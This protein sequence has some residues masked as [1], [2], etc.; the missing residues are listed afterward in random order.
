MQKQPKLH[1][2]PSTHWDREWYQ[3]FQDYR[4]RL[5]GLIDDVLE[6]L[7]DET[8][9]GPFTADGQ[10][11]LIEDYLEI[12]PERAETLRLYT[13]SGQ[14]RFGPWYVLPDEFLVCGESLIRN[15]RFGREVVCDFGGT[16]SNAGFLC[17]L[18]GH[19]SQMPQIFDGFGI[20]GALV[21]RGVDSRIG[22]G[23]LWQGADG[24]TLPT[25][26]FGKSGYCDYTYKV[27][28]SNKPESIFED[29]KAREDLRVFIEE[30]IQRVGPISH[31]LIFDGGDHLQIDPDHYGVLKDLIASDNL[32]Y[33]VIHSDLDT[34]LEG[35]GANLTTSHPRLVGELREPARWPTSE[36]MQFLIPGCTASRVWI[37]QANASCESLLIDWVEPFA[38]FAHYL[39]GKEYPTAFLR[40]AWKWLLQNHPHDS[41]CGCSVDQVH[42]DMRY[43]F[44]QCRQIA[45]RLKH[46]SL[47][48]LAI[49]SQ[50][51][52]NEHQCGVFLFN[53]LPVERKQAVLLFD[54]EIPAEWPEFTEFFGY[55]PKPAFRL[56]DPTTGNEVPYQRL[57]TQRLRTRKQTRKL[58]YPRVYK[59]HLVRVAARLDLPALGF[60][61][62][63]IAATENGQNGS[64]HLGNRHV[65]ATRHPSVPG[66]RTASNRIENQYLALTFDLSGTLT[67]E[68]KQNSQTYSGLNLFVSDADIG[69]G[70]YHGPIVNGREIHGGL[71]KTQLEV[72][73]DTPLVTTMVVRQEMELPISY[74]HGSQARS[75]NRRS[76]LI[77]SSV[78]L[79]ADSQ[80]VEIETTL[81]NSV[82][83][84]R[85]RV[86]FPTHANSAHYWSDSAFDV[87]ERSIAL[88]PDNHLYRELEVETKPQQS[89]SAVFD[90]TRGLALITPGGLLETSVPD[91][92]DRAIALTLFRATGRTKMTDGEP[93]GQL[94]HQPLTF[95]YRVLPLRGAPTPADLFL[96]ARDL[97]AGI[98][99]VHIDRMIASEKQKKSPS[100]EPFQ[101]LFTLRGPAVLSSIQQIKGEFEVRLFNPE[102]NSVNAEIHFFGNQ[103]FEYWQPVD[104]ESN[105][106]GDPVKM[107]EGRL[108]IHLARKQ[109]KTFRS[110]TKAQ[111]S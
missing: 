37:K 90:D 5:V 14:I 34:F 103:P 69:D 40:T 12:R 64:D 38:A 13:A 33:E 110:A 44:S 74:D 80:S 7:G 57:T 66:L 1:Y 22:A 86:L 98:G 97:A 41:I 20:T 68:D 46:E 65:P 82:A 27:R 105:P 56:F 63:R 51:E 10:A 79:R 47:L 55:E 23:F 84:H 30:E 71:G 15:I 94:F 76:L 99:V 75:S 95:R 35:F 9:I 93:D 16:P 42:E 17:D 107:V 111:T 19:N 48:A 89:W 45:E 58:H 83:D 8:L 91:R 39:L 59:V 60:R 26:R 104:L 81:T 67:L 88:R 36:D 96:E 3:P 6:K 73:C 72:V 43:R 11:I 54:L 24:T 52:I 62:L 21:W 18:F 106:I 101:G 100:L 50:P 53:P 70:W 92:P 109:L 25:Y 87:V 28:H 85:L 61:S 29:A 2:V 108:Q 31:G 102:E 32:G 49:A 77:E 4:F 78:T